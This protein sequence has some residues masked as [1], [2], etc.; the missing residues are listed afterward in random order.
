[1]TF[2]CR[3]RSF[4]AL[5]MW[6]FMVSLFTFSIFYRSHR[7]SQVC[8]SAASSA[9]VSCYISRLYGDLRQKTGNFRC[10]VGMVSN[11]VSFSGRP[12]RYPSFC[13][14]LLFVTPDLKT[15]SFGDFSLRTIIFPDSSYCAY[16]EAFWRSLEP[17]VL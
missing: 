17:Q 2:R 12:G 4:W 13:R 7:L 5:F 8:L 3:I 9:G 16:L 14:D 15:I 11:L 1:M 6:V 10:L